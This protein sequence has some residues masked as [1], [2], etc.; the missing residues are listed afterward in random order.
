MQILSNGGMTTSLAICV[1]PLKKNLPKQKRVW[2]FKSWGDRN[3]RYYYSCIAFRVSTLVSIAPFR[4]TNDFG[5]MSRHEGDPVPHEHQFYRTTLE[6]LFSLNLKASGTF[7][8][9]QKTGFRNLDDVR[10]EIAKDKG[11]NELKDEKA[12]R[13][14]TDERIERLDCIV[15]RD[16]T[17]RRRSQTNAS[18][19]WCLTRRSNYGSHKRRQ[20]YLQP[21]DQRE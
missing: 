13:L 6:G 5:V 17:I 12:Y 10:I 1:R 9:K 20:P 2:F 8:Y 11:L 16:G 4:P 21:C 3:I 18:L 19:Y 15:S 14:P 7:W